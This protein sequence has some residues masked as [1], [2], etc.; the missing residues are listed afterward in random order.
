MARYF[1]CSC[2][3][4]SPVLGIIVAEAVAVVVVAVFAAAAH[5]VAEDFGAVE[6]VHVAPCLTVSL[7]AEVIS[8]PRDSL[9]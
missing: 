5:L 3:V 2:T 8:T 9:F 7:A 4:L 6:A 1:T